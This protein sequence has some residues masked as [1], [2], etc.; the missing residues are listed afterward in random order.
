MKTGISNAL[1]PGYASGIVRGVRNEMPIIPR[2]RITDAF[3]PQYLTQMMEEFRAEE[4]Q[5][6]NI[7][8]QLFVRMLNFLSKRNGTF[9]P[10]LVKY[11]QYSEQ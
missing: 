4:R 7:L 2:R 11:E 10:A 5:P 9:D 8:Y 3:D 6:Q 1:D